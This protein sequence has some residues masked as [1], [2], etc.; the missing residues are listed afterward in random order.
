[1]QKVVIIIPVYKNKLSKSEQASLN[2]CIKILGKYPLK[3]ICP[4]DL[5]INFYEKLLTEKNCNFSFEKFDKNHFKNLMNYSKLLL[6]KNFYKRFLGYEFLLI[7]QLDA[8][9]F[10][11]KLEYWCDKNYDYIGAPWFEGFA[12]A[13]EDSQ[14][15]PIAGN[16][17]FSLRKTSSLFNLL[18]KKYIKIKSFEEI[19]SRRK[20]KKRG[21]ISEILHTQ[22][23]LLEYLFQ[24]QRFF[25]FW[26]VTNLY[27]DCAIVKY[28]KEA[29]IDFKIAPPDVA[30]QF[31]FEA[32]PRRLY[33]MNN[34]NLPFGC[35][36]FEKYDFDFWKQFINI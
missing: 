2:Q 7:Y 17:G 15:M 32:Q 20:N 18:S 23:C 11:D 1:M 19:S 12:F 36:A 9:I 34:N 28:G 5:D 13:N 10:E 25:S 8:W 31:S 35:H 4:K 29:Y 33:E 16:G 30:L 6:N 22:I 3:F 27:E 14:I 24:K 21:K 26:K